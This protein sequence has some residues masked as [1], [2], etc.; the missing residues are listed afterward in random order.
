[1]N[2]QIKKQIIQRDNFSCVKCGFYDK[3]GEDLKIH[4]L[5][6]RTSEKEDRKDDFV[7]LCP[8]C[9][10]HAPENPKKLRE[11]LS[12]KIDGKLLDTFRKPE[13]DISK[14]TKIGMNSSFSK[15]NHLSKAP[16][17]YKFFDKKLVP[18][19]NFESIRGIFKE[20]LNTNISL[21]QL[22]KR[23]NLTTTG[24][25]K[26]IQNRTYLGKVKLSGKE[27]QG[28]HQPLISLELFQKVQNKLKKIKN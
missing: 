6:S 13:N 17:G 20:F 19:E 21:T 4:P 2:P 26:L 10:K 25:I 14:K 16:R 11:Y 15:G 23:N 1:M 24:L 9:Y 8:I 18:D 12:E 22:A 7:T 28:S 3:K 27:I 5:I